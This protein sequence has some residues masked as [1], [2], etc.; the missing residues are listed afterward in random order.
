MPAPVTLERDGALAIVT[1]A[2]P[3][4]NLFDEEMLAALRAAV[5]AVAADPPLTARPSARTSRPRG[6]SAAR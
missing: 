3:P 1:L 4:L 6:G 2:R 5:D